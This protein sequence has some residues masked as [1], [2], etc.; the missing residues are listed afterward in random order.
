VKMKR[1]LVTLGLSAGLLQ[2]SASLAQQTTTETCDVPVVVASYDNQLVRDLSP[3][4]FSVQV[5]G[6]PV[7]VVSTEIDGGPKRIALILDA[8]KNIPDDEWKLETEMAQSFVENARPEDQF[9]FVVVGAEGTAAAF[10]SPDDVTSQLRKL[11]A[12]RPVSA[13]ATEKNF[14]AILAAANRLDP[15][16]FGD[17]IFLF[18]HSV[19]AGSTADY[20]H[21]LELVQKNSLR[22]Y[23]MSFAD[24][25][26]KLPSGS[27]LNKPQRFE[28]SELEML[29][30]ATGYYFSFH[31]AR[32][33]NQ[34]RQL[35]LFKG[36][37]ADLYTWISRP[38]RL[39]IPATAIKASSKFEV[40]VADAKTRKIRNG[41][42]HYPQSINPCATQKAP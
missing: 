40:T 6:A 4:D 10:L 35:P 5:G 22:F 26:P 14:D 30:A 2:S 18:G 17:A 33:L 42:I 21:V 9:A 37:L 3:L 12:S 19:D 24:S 7:S 36:F 27:D 16:Q 38:Y 28:R 34:P 31:T 20:D 39:A 11:A 1:F 13:D 29:S 23:G 41:G 8:S 15:P 32:A 25:L